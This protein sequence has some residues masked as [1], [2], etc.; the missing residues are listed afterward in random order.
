MSSGTRHEDESCGENK[1]STKKSLQQQTSFETA[2]D[3]HCQSASAKRSKLEDS[4]RSISPPD[5][6]SESNLANPRLN[7]LLLFIYYYKYTST[8]ALKSNF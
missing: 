6:N 4:P 8:Y 1:D 3:S 7:G 2:D 5:V